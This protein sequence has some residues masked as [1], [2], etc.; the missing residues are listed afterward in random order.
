MITVFSRGS[1]ASL[2]YYQ[3]QFIL[4]VDLFLASNVKVTAF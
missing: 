3:D 4:Q 1:W 2:N